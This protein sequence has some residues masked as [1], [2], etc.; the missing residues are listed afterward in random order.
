MNPC[1][2]DICFLSE[3]VTLKVHS[4]D[5][6]VFSAGEYY[7]TS[8]LNITNTKDI[9]MRG[10]GDVTISHDYPYDF[11]SITEVTTIQC[12]SSSGGLNFSNISNLS[13]LN[14]R[15]IGCGNG[16]N[17]AAIYLTN[18]TNFNMSGVTILYSNSTGLYGYAV[19]GE[20]WITSS[21][22]LGSTSGVILQNSSASI[23]SSTFANC[24]RGIQF[25]NTL[26]EVSLCHFIDQK[27]SGISSAADDGS[28]MASGSTLEVFEST[29]NNCTFGMKMTSEP[30][31]NVSESTFNNCTYGMHL[32]LSNA[33]CYICTFTANK[34][35]SMVVDS[36]FQ[37]ANSQYISNYVGI[38][39]LSS[40]TLLKNASFYGG[41]IHC[42]RA[43]SSKLSVTGNTSF[44]NCRSYSYGGA[45]YLSRSVVNF[46]APAN[47]TFSNNVAAQGG[48]V[49]VEPW[50]KLFTKE[51]CFFQVNDS[52]GTL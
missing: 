45:L 37:I 48:A 17:A 34:F 51:N 3:D 38:F 52:N 16:A 20:N 30:M 47:V 32:N 44:T 1:V 39:A 42:A 12:N 13:L 35:G 7:L 14:L 9:T 49:Y 31:L 50:I 8:V 24:S 28:L 15:F 2:G 27:E 40:T 19:I 41:T 11:D 36:S 23:S 4:G 22:F 46:V 18:V 6:M 5:V 33:G 10:S 25:Q 26:L 21:F 29:F 43:V